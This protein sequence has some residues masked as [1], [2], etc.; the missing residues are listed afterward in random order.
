MA[1]SFC[2]LYL[3]LLLLKLLGGIWHILTKTKPFAWA[4]R[5][6]CFVS[7]L[8]LLKLSPWF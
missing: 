4:R 3:F 7:F 1:S 6:L 2:V 8:L 5:F